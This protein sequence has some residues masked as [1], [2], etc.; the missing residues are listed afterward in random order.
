M[1]TP[2]PSL[3]NRVCVQQY[4]LRQQFVIFGKQSAALARHASPRAGLR[5]V[6]SSAKASPEHSITLTTVGS[7]LP[8]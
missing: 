8:S 4:E 5:S 1:A 7:G 2:E 3:S 6:S